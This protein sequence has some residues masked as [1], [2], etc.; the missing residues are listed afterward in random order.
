MKII[1]LGQTVFVKNLVTTRS[2][3]INLKV[4]QQGLVRALKLTKKNLKLLMVEFKDHSRV[5]FF[6]EELK[7]I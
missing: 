3:Q 5:W 6:E 4:G 2:P 1:S 7:L